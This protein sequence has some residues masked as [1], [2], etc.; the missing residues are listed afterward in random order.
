VTARILYMNW[1]GGIGGAETALF[2]LIK[3]LDRE[4]YRPIVWQM[5]EG[6]FARKILEMGIPVP[7]RAF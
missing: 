5:Q 4:N 7:E 1:S 2:R 3:A 6:I